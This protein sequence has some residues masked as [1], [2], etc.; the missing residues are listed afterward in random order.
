MKYLD[1][2]EA[3][4]GDILN[5]RG[6][7]VDVPGVVLKIVLPQT[8]DAEDWSLPGGGVLIEGGGLGLFTTE[9]LEDDEDIVF[10]RRGE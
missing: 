9:H 7:G 5:V 1:G 6:E 2:T 4:V 8:K 3:Q 10:V